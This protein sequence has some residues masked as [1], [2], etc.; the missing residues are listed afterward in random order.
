[1]SN[2]DDR[3]SPSL[4][5]SALLLRLF[6]S[7]VYAPEYLHQLTEM[8]RSEPTTHGTPAFADIPVATYRRSLPF[9]YLQRVG[10]S[11]DDH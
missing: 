4:G 9:T 11:Q 10:K 6:V 5:A 3:N 2:F 8:M 7:F 1:M